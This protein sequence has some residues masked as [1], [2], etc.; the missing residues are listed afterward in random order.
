MLIS[1]EVLLCI[2]LLT[3]VCI[4]VAGGKNRGRAMDWVVAFGMFVITLAGL[5]WSSSGQ[6]FGGMFISD[7]ATRL[8]K[9]VLNLG[10]LIVVLQSRDWLSKE[11]NSPR[12]AEYYSLLIS[13]LIG[14]SFLISSGD[15]IM[16]FIGIELATLPLAALASFEINS[17][18]SAEAGIKMIF[19]S[20]FASAISLMGISMIYG[21]GGSIYFSQIAVADLYS[22]FFI[23]AFIFF[24]TGLAFKISLVPFHFWTADVYEGS[25]MNITSYFS[26]ISKGSALF[27]L[28]L[29]FFKFFHFGEG[30]WQIPVYIISVL[31]MTVGNLF[32]LR[33]KN[34][35]RF[36]AYSSI[37]QAGFLLLGI[38]SS[39]PSGFNAVVYFML[40]YVFSNLGAFGVA[41]VISHHSGKEEID[42]YNGLY[43]TNPKL[44]LLMLLSLFSLAGIP[45]LAGFFGKFF[46]FMSAAE[47]HNYVLV[48][49]ATLNATLSLY[50]Y[51]LL[52]KAMFINS[53]EAPIPPIRSGS[54]A[55]LAMLICLAGML[56][57]G[58]IG[59][60]H[61]FIQ[62]I[63]EKFML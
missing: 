32:A 18:R 38:Y 2:L 42:D 30:L 9:A 41:A 12:K 61:G 33:Q 39:S 3:V 37:A 56:A 35:K 29:I 22:P 54:Q 16:F 17:R 43:K 26:V 47:T 48:L 19:S 53:N 14:M 36:L 51:L 34:I 50:Y 15:F 28:L 10:T 27:I 13:T 5:S 58:F 57:I 8:M 62:R 23:L 59:P 11:V 1:N 44:S 45:P 6:L 21:Y 25:P 60:L 31:T 40:I 24:F 63:A 20:A 55:R 4:E 7:D 52:V 49:I 46:L